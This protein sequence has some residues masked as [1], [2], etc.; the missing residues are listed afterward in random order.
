MAI[1]VG[2]G[3]GVIPQKSSHCSPTHTSIYPLW[4]QYPR[5]LTSIYPHRQINPPPALLQ[6]N[7][8]ILGRTFNS[9]EY[10]SKEPAHFII[11]L[12]WVCPCPQIT[13]TYEQSLVLSVDCLSITKL[14]FLYA[15]HCSYVTDLPSLN[16]DTTF[17]SLQF[18]SHQ[19]W[20]LIIQ[21]YNM[22]FF[23]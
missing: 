1:S 14:A 2:E 4:I 22:S 10:F 9:G 11:N 12:F 7:G 16:I 23:C 5:N 13:V 3:G 15:V 20:S 21:V 8:R 6:Q 19:L 17:E 18:K